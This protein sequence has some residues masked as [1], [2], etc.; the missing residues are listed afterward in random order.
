MS[1]KSIWVLSSLFLSCNS[2][3]LFPHRQSWAISRCPSSPPTALSL[4]SSKN[5]KELS[6]WVIENLDDEASTSTSSTKAGENDNLPSGGLCISKFHIQASLSETPTLDEFIPIRLLVGRSGWGTGVHPTTR[7][8]LEWLAREEVIIGGE[9]I[10]DYGCGSGVLSIAALGLG[11]SM[12]V[13]VD[14]EAEALVT[15]QANIELNGYGDRF[16]GLHT[17]EI[18]PFFFSSSRSGCL[19]CKYSRRAI[20]SA[21]N[22]ICNYNKSGTECFVLHVWNKTQRS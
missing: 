11:A 16:E 10:L 6:D 19:C 3:F 21:F 22:G 12:A 18:V 5:S 13:G 1:A 9:S 2:F 15:C 17:R 14:V 8:C 20:G 4:P 7:L